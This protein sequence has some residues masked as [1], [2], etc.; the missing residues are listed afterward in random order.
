MRLF[1]PLFFCALPLLAAPPPIVTPAQSSPEES[2]AAHEVRRY[3]YLR[4][5]QLPPIRTFSGKTGKA[6]IFIARKDQ[7]EMQAMA[8]EASAREAAAALQPQE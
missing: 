8:A 2:L 3:I 6:F 5:G 1:L 4:T 7:P